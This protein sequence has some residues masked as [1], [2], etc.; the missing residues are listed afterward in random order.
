MLLQLSLLQL[1]LVHQAQLLLVLLVLLVCVRWN[2]NT[3]GQDPTTTA[4]SQASGPPHLPTT[5]AGAG[6]TLA[7]L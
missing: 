5:G 6:A 4:A 1:L 7:G 3:T 2:T